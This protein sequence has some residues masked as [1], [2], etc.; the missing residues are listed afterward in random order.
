MGRL[1]CIFPIFFIYVKVRS[2]F[3]QALLL[4][5]FF[6]FR[7]YSILKSAQ[8]DLSVLHSQEEN[9]NAVKKILPRSEISAACK[10]EQKQVL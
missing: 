9:V 2:I 1:F 10:F 8:L 5:Y 3:V 4:I 6:S 7:I